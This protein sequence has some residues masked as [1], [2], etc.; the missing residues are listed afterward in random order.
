MSNLSHQAEHYRD[1]AD[2]CRQL[3]TFSVSNKLKCR[4][5]Q[6]ADRYGKL[7]ESEEQRLC[8]ADRRDGIACEAQRAGVAA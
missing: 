6:M 8:Y 1:M 5:S 2:E 7:A 4:F 3:S